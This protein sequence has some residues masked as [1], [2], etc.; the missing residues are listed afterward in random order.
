MTDQTLGNC[1]QGCGG[2]TF[3]HLLVGRVQ[4]SSTCGRHHNIRGADIRFNAGRGGLQAPTQL[5]N[6]DKQPNRQ[7][8]ESTT[9]LGTG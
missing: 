9:S 7:F 8:D 6:R 3:G 5:E 4:K 2:V 1:G